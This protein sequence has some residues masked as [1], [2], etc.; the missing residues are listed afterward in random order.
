MKRII[1]DEIASTNTFAAQNSSEL[2]SGTTIIARSQTAGR[3]QRGNSWEAEPGKNLTFCIFLRPENFPARQQFFIS[4]AF[5]LAIV[6]ALEKCGVTAKIKWPNDIYVG[7]RKICGILIEHAVLGMNLLHTIAG[8]GININQREF[9]SDAPNP[10]SLYQLLG[11][12]SDLNSI[13]EDV[14]QRFEHRLGLLHDEKSAHAQHQEFL[15]TLWRGN[16]EFHPYRDVATQRI[17]RARIVDVQPLGHLHLEEENGE[18]H[19]Y[20]FKEVEFI[21]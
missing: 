7:D 11:R 4:E 10:V 9:R 8:A 20:A 13:L 3:G 17:F 5:A 6:D 2:E 12:E 14:E 1:L 18:P 19:L 16:G 21:L 15:S